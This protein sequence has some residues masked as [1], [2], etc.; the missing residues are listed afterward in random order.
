MSNNEKFT[1]FR[2][3]LTFFEGYNWSVDIPCPVFPTL[4]IRR[5]CGAFLVKRLCLPT[6]A[7]SKVWI[8]AA[9]KPMV[10]LKCGCSDIHRSKRR[11]AIEWI[12]KRF[13]I[14]PWR[15]MRCQRRF[16][17]HLRHTKL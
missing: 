17:F 6:I 7:G 8:E 12:L 11:G 4:Q 13:L 10:C 5:P 3:K 15:C 16:F 2:Y 9:M 1:I 14:V